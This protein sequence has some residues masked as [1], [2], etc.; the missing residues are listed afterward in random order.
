MSAVRR[1]SVAALTSAVALA[2]CAIPAHASLFHHTHDITV[3]TSD[4]G[5]DH[6]MGSQIRRHEGGHV[7][8]G[9]PFTHDNRIDSLLHPS[10]NIYALQQSGKGVYGL[11]VSSHDGNK[12]NWPAVVRGGRHFVW[13]KATEGTS[14]RNPHF[15][16]QY[17][18]PARAGMVRGAYHFAW[19]GNSSGR[20]QATYFSN[21]G[22]GWSP[23]GHTLPGA[24]DLEWAPK[25]NACYNQSQTQMATWIKDFVTTYKARWGRA[26][27]IYTSASW[28]NKCV[29][30]AANS[31]VSQ[32]PLWVAR[33]SSSAGTM[34]KGWRN[35]TVWQYSDTGFDHDWMRGDVSTLKT[36]SKRR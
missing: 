19:P 32:T 31:T 27:I 22:G 34:P 20:A 9:D 4:E 12:T 16:S 11:D 5:G 36:W 14:Y 23:D 13:A 25:G 28:W 2:T 26:P 24:L 15:A 1:L 33:Y 18:G 7:A 29:G 17:N 8:K 10:P 30:T 35:F 6:T 3:S 21:H